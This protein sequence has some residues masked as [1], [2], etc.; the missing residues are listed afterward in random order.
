[1]AR[2]FVEEDTPGEPD[3]G[4]D[5][6][7]ESDNVSDGDVPEGEPPPMTLVPLETETETV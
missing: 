5:D 3:D 7:D 6:S 1:M 4:D 2:R